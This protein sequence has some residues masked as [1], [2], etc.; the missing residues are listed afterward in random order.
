MAALRRL[1]RR[2][3]R[4]GAGHLGQRGAAAD[5]RARRAPRRPS[6]RPDASVARRRR[7]RRPRPLLGN[8]RLV[9]LDQRAE[10]LLAE[11]PPPPP[12]PRAGSA[13]VVQAV[14]AAPTL[15]AGLVARGW[16]VSAS[17]RTAV[18]ARQ[19]SARE[20]LGALSA[21]AVLFASGSAARAWV[22]VFGTTTPP[23]VVAMGPQTAVAAARRRAVGH[24]Q[25]PATTPSPAS[26]PPSSTRSLTAHD[27]VSVAW[28][29][30]ARSEAGRVSG[31]GGG[32]VRCRG[33]DGS[34]CWRLTIAAQLTRSQA[35]SRVPRRRSLVRRR[36]RGR[37]PGR[38]PPPRRAERAERR[39]R[40][41]SCFRDAAR[42][43]SLSAD[44]RLVVY[45]AAPADDDGRTSS[46]WLLDRSTGTTTELTPCAR[47]AARRQQR[48]PGD[49]RRRVPR[50][51]RHRDPLRPVP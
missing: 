48:P 41:S 16:R 45:A 10:G 46:I 5:G 9:P 49:Q 8:C 12:P 2:S 25:S 28:T 34:G 29:R 19:P 33:R 3:V 37:R 26:S 20:Q 13:L 36:L 47:R 15:V 23:V 18:S 1:R 50:R 40:R 32:E 7:Q 51:R 24:R 31:L 17:R 4:L 38:R 30:R 43:P 27:R 6:A 22:E 42:T 44:G 14:D 35:P 39:S 21:D 11:L